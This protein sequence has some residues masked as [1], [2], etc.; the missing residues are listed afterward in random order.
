MTREGAPRPAVMRGPVPRRDPCP[1][2]GSRTRGADGAPA[3]ENSALPGILGEIAEAAGLQTAIG[4]ALAWG[5][6]DVHIPQPGHIEQHPDHPLAVLL[7]A[8]GTAAAVAELLGGNKVYFPRARRACARHLANAGAGA[9]EIADRLG[10]T[11]SA[12]R[13]YTRKG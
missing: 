9:G 3:A 13:R 8:E 10:I 2:A 12:A 4:L 11:R 6:R 7:A 1:G 5:G